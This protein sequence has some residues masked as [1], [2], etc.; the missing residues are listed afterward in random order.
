MKKTL[1]IFFILCWGI[2]AFAGNIGRGTS[3]RNEFAFKTFDATALSN[4]VFS[5]ETELSM[6][7]LQ[8]YSSLFPPDTTNDSTIC[9]GDSAIIIGDS[10]ICAG[11]STTLTAS[12]G[13]IYSWN[14][15]DSTAIIVVS[16]DSTTTY[17]VIVTNELGCIDTASFTITVNPLP[18]AVITASDTTIC[19]GDS[20]TLTASGGGTYLWN[21]S[22][23]TPGIFVAPLTTTTYGVTVTNDYGC[24]DT[25]A[26][27]VI[28]N[29]GCNGDSA[30]IIGDSAICA[31][32]SVTLTAY[33]GVSYE[34]NTSDST[35]IIVVVPDSTTT[36]TV[37]VT[38]EYGCTDTATFTV[39]VDC[40]KITGKTMY[41]GKANPGSAPNPP[42]YNSRIYDIN[43]V[44]VILKD[45]SGSTIASTLSDANGAFSFSNIDY[46]D[47]KLVYDKYTADTMQWCNDI[48]AIDAA[49]ILYNIGSD[50]TTDPSRNFS[51]IYKKAADVDNSGA[52]TSID[53]SRILAKI[54]APSDPTKNFPKGNWVNLEKL[55]TVDGNI[56][57]ILPV[58]SYGDYNASS[59]KYKDSTNTW[60]QAKSLPD[61]NIVYSSG[62]SMIVN[63]SG[64][65]E[66]PLHISMA[67]KDFSTLGLDLSYSADKFKLVGASMPNTKYDGGVSKIN[68]TLQEIIDNNDDLVVTDENGRI[69]VVFTTTN[70][71][72]VA[73]ND[74]L[75]N[76][77]FRPLSKLE[78][79][80]ID[81]K[82]AGTG[83][84]ADQSAQENDEVYLTM[85]KVYV[86]GNNSESSF[87]VAGYPNPFSNDVTLT[88]S[89]P[90]NGT[91]KLSVY[92]A[93]GEL[94]SE[95]INEKQ[96]CGKHT[97]VFSQKNLPSGI[98]TFRL[99]FTGDH[100]SKCLKLKMVH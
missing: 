38:N 77:G 84:I 72:D 8:E 54:S 14:T 35:A 34:W 50:T 45:L 80:A 23:T 15:S 62:E 16:P 90:E 56:N 64:I 47:Y 12:G 22:A 67:M 39:I 3:I 37:I 82:L 97:T 36:Y 88:Y 66:I 20:V 75:I 60:S 61:N 13:V 31:G 81:F 52:M 48:N 43:K 51:R 78:Q 33:G 5:I 4:W 32:D 46:G 1:T 19:A 11:D 42:T 83:V 40:G 76:L 2:V 25:A 28:V 57:V 74:I 100:T 59:S 85:P 24:T 94:I 6:L 44:T 86:Q 21:T 79:G 99:D 96:L 18:D 29:C 65:I 9:N 55:I 98:Y 92:N 87:E 10:A 71:F 26:F 95:L 69:R 70:Y 89:L 68:P 58:I 27:T 93:L 41:E 17:I 53:R 91:V 30:I 63:N 49:L 73:D 7:T